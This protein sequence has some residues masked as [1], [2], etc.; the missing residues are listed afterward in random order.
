VGVGSRG[1]GLDGILGRWGL[2]CGSWM[3]GKVCGVRFVLFR[4]MSG[5]SMGSSYRFHPKLN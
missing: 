4:M 3:R 5:C 2:F 1:R